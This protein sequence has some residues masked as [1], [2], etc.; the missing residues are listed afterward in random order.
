MFNL[1]LFNNNFISSEE[2]QNKHHSRIDNHR[3]TEV[4][5]D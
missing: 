4:S 2:P 3:N 5:Q 1:F